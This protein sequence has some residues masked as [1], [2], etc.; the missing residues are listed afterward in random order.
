M[1]TTTYR[2][3]TITLYDNGPL[4]IRQD[5]EHLSRIDGWDMMLDGGIPYPTIQ[6]AREFIDWA[7]NDG[8]VKRRD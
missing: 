8:E 3:H 6:E 4:M 2:G 1:T 7:W 5:N